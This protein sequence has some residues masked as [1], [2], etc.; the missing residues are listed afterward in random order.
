MPTQKRARVVQSSVIYLAERGFHARTIARRTG[1]SVN[2]IYN[3]CR[4]LGIR[5]RDYRDGVGEIAER[6][7]QATPCVRMHVVARK[8]DRLVVV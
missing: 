7:I 5:L 1:L 4:K 8:G 3:A 2:Q 6:I